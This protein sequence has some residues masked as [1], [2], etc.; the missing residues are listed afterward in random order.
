MKIRKVLFSLFS[1]LVCVSASYATTAASKP[2]IYVGVQG[3]YANTNFGLSTMQ[4]TSDN[5]SQPLIAAAIH[6]HVFGARGYVGYQ[7]NDYV[8]VEAGYLRVRNTRYTN[9]Y[10]SGTTAPTLIPNGDITEYGVDISGKVFLPMAAYIH[11][12]PYLKIGGEYMNAQ[13]HGGITSASNSDFGY[14]LHPLLGAGIGYNLA[15]SLTVDLSWTTMTKRNSNV[16][17][18]DMYFLGLTYHFSPDDIQGGPPNYGDV[19]N[20]DP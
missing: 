1:T 12:S 20:N 6:N 4:S 16:P 3:G 17:R 14:S 5:G 15:P 8:A 11:L 13:S 2:Q 9:V 10:I 18:I 19:D 7:F